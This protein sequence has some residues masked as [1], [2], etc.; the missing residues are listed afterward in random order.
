MRKTTLTT[1]K[2]GIACHSSYLDAIEAISCISSVQAL[3]EYCNHLKK[4]VSADYFWY[5]I[6][7]N[8]PSKSLKMQLSINDYPEGFTKPFINDGYMQ[9]GPVMTR[10]YQQTNGV[11]TWSELLALGTLHNKENK[12]LEWAANFD[13]TDGISCPIQGYQNEFVILHFA[14]NAHNAKMKQDLAQKKLFLKLL[15]PALYLRI[16]ALFDGDNKQHPHHLTT[17]EHEV[18]LW[19]ARGKTTWE[20]AVILDISA[21]T[22]KHHIE[23]AIVKLAAN[24]RSEA[25]AKAIAY[26]II[27][28]RDITE[29]YSTNLVLE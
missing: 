15:S 21:H 11:Y 5:S 27:N 29:Y 6:I 16:N 8:F 2:I 10:S 9:N 4:L 20:I 24:N 19:T 25:I 13:I 17:R 28:Y 12:S 26:N 18:M 14:T 1:S 7:T 23:R 3:S 22:V